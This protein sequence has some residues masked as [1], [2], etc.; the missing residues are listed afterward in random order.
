LNFSGV[1]KISD[2]LFGHPVAALQ[3]MRLDALMPD[4]QV[5]VLLAS[6]TG[7]VRHL[8][9]TAVNMTACHASGRE[10][11]VEVS[12][13]EHTFAGERYITGIIRDVSERL[14]LS[15]QLL[16]AQKME[17]LGRLTGGIARDFN[18]L[19]TAINGYAEISLPELDPRDPVYARLQDIRRAAERASDLTRK[20]LTFSRNQPMQLR[21]FDLNRLLTDLTPMLK[22]LIGEDITVI[23]A[24]AASSLAIH[25]DP[26]QID[27]AVINLAVNARD[28]MPHGGRLTVTTELVLLDEI[29]AARHTHGRAGRFACLRV[30]DTGTGIHPKDLPHIFEPFF[31]TKD[32]ERG[33]G[34]GLAITYGVVHQHHGW[35]EVSSTQGKGTVFTLWLPLADGVDE[36]STQPVERVLPGG[37]E[38][39]L[40]VEDEEPVRLILF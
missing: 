14:R 13:T 9:W 29:A 20:L 16:Q 23:T 10:I 36:T 25:A 24:P 18:N 12:L 32:A 30:A 38:T 11:A 39:I 28:A 5:R 15:A 8:P 6:G 35:I 2:V 3:G 17:A 31:T 1:A 27:Q 33:T 4:E 21:R 19:L 37:S 40:L 22:R 34:L 26:S 7:P